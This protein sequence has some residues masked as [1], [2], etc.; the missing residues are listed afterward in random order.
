M[1]KLGNSPETLSP[2]AALI[3]G[4]IRNSD[5]S[6]PFLLPDQDFDD[7]WYEPLDFEIDTELGR[8]RPVLAMQEDFASGRIQDAWVTFLQ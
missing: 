7:L 3:A 1:R 2:N 5:R 8:K 4:G 6:S